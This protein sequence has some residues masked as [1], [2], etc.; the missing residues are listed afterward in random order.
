LDEVSTVPL[1]PTTTYPIP[2][3]QV[4]AL[5][6]WVTPFVR[7]VQVIPSGEVR[8]VAL[9][10]TAT[11][12]PAPKHIAAKVFAVGLVWTVQ[13]V[14]SGDVSI[15]PDVNASLNPISTAV[16]GTINV[17]PLV[18]ENYLNGEIGHE[19]AHALQYAADP[20]LRAAE[21]EGLSPGFI[22]DLEMQ[23]N[24]IGFGSDR[25]FMA[26]ISGYVQ[27]YPKTAAAITVG[28]IFGAYGASS[29]LS[30]DTSD[31]SAP[32]LSKH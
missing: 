18:S 7:D 4:I 5:S 32:L 28:S 21:L 6:D 24:R 19:F 3:T 8:V 14:P 25:A 20:G 17:F 23:A 27:A 2:S 9:A 12:W 15:R 16:P 11:N 26:G 30:S 31:I 1:V 22:T 13:V 10:P 29:W